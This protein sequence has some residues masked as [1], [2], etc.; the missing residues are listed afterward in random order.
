MF[1][2]ETAR[3]FYELL[4]QSP[5]LV[6]LIDFTSLKAGSETIAYHLGFWGEGKLIVYK[7][8]FDPALQKAG[9]GTVLMVRLMHRAASR[10]CLEFDLGRGGENYKGRFTNASHM[11]YDWRAFSSPRR[12]LLHAAKGHVRLQHPEFAKRLGALSHGIRTAL[13]KVPFWKA[14]A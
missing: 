14:S 1:C 8:C 5:E 10:G 2:E 6:P 11:L 12:R 4:V 9:P 3:K 13:K 7:W